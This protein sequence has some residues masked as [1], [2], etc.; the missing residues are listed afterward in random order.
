MATHPTTSQRS[1]DELIES[2]ISEHPELARD[3]TLL[4]R[5]LDWKGHADNVITVF[6]Y[7]GM[8]KTGGLLAKLKSALGRFSVPGLSEV[9]FIV[10]TL[11]DIGKANLTAV[12]YFGHKAYAYGVTAWVFGHKP[13]PPPKKDLEKLQQ[14]ISGDRRSKR[15]EEEWVK[16]RDAAI[17][18]M[19]RRCT[20]NRIPSRL[21][22]DWLRMKYE[23]QPKKLA[24]T[25]YTA[26]EA[27]MSLTPFEKEA[28]AKLKC[29]YPK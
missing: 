27:T 23:H 16:M 15:A 18:A 4:K 13:P 28:H 3:R 2:L 5:F 7:L 11:C 19:I 6:E 9:L 21:F 24:Q 25:I 14:W 10:D 12:K 26:F 20:Y 22:K 29:N 1:K 8:I 17:I